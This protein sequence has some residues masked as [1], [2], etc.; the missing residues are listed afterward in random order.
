MKI[1][2]IVSALLSL[3]MLCGAFSLLVFADETAEP[4]YTYNTSNLKPTLFNYYKGQLNND[5]DAPISTPEEK[6]ATMDLRMEK[7]GYRFYIDAY[8]GEIALQSIETGEILFSNPYDIGTST[9]TDNVKKRLL[10]QIAVEF[11]EISTGTTNTYY[12][13]DEAAQRGQI[14][15]KEIRNGIRVEYTIGRLASRMLVPVMISEEDFQE[16]IYQVMKAKVETEEDEFKLKQ[17]ESYYPL[18]DPAQVADFPQLLDDMYKSYPITKKMPVRVLETT[19]RN[20]VQMARIEQIIKK[21]CPDFTYEDLDDAHNKVEYES[22]DKNLP[23]FKL[24]LEYS[25]DKNGLVVRQPANGLRFNETIV[26][27]NK[28]E[29]LPYMG[30]GKDPNEG[31]TFFPD[32]SGALFDFQ[33]IASL[34]KSAI[35]SGK[36]YGSD[37]AYHVLTGTY[38]Q[39]IRYPVFGIVENQALTRVVLGTDS[40]GNPIKINETYYKK[41]GFVGIVLDGDALMDLFVEHAVTEHKYNTV[42][43]KV[44][45]RPTD[46][47][48][49]ADVISVVKDNQKQTVVSQRKFTGNYRIRYML[50]TSP[51]VANEKNIEIL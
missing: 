41:R 28:Y 13:F 8:S 12:S 23:L 22:E 47:Y 17:L 45:P 24:A 7:D 9:A 16:K 2:R 34:K 6:L 35:F 40:E 27:V 10:S 1:K 31:Y 33:K 46:T 38:Q 44:N 4:V 3:I 51:E 42:K 26:R 49:L 11:T 21:F 48:D 14:V 20:A 30:A 18:K 15:V 37:F 36:V 39:T 43:I 32:G 50:L 19:A 5:K 29:I 25:I